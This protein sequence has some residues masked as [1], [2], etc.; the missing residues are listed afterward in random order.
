MIKL[1]RRFI[2]KP[3]PSQGQEALPALKAGVARLKRETVK[4]VKFQFVD[5]RE[6]IKF[7]YVFKLVEAIAAALNQSLMDRFRGYMTDLSQISAVL[8]QKDTDARQTCQRLQTMAQ[9]SRATA[10]D[11]RCLQADLAA[12]VGTDTTHR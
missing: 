10:D 8:D 9:T 12:A 3:M 7:Q 6:N 5:Y 4:S 11:I 2:K 1:V